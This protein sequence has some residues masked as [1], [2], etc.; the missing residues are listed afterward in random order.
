M[1][2]QPS[3]D[4]VWTETQGV[5]ITASVWQWDTKCSLHCRWLRRFQSRLLPPS[6][7]NRKGRMSHPRWWSTAVTINPTSYCH[8][9]ILHFQATKFLPCEHRPCATPGIPNRRQLFRLRMCSCSQVN[10]PSYE[11]PCSFVCTWIYPTWTCITI[12]TKYLTKI[13]TSAF[14][15]RCQ[16]LYVFNSRGHSRSADC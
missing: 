14:R 5:S 3:D 4:E 11:G 1:S 10:T 7:F 12:N 15:V 8:N 13:I 6:Y 16:N 2:E 9:T